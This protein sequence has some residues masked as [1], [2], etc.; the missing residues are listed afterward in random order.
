MHGSGMS[1]D[2]IRH[3]MRGG[4]S[5]Q[6]RQ[7]PVED[8][9]LSP[10]APDEL[11]KFASM[12]ESQSR[13]R[14]NFQFPGNQKILLDVYRDNDE[15]IADFGLECFEFLQKRQAM[16]APGLPE[17]YEHRDGGAF[18]EPVKLPV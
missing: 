12:I 13:E 4:W 1:C 6:I 7:H 18:D 16:T 5:I 3:F 2:V 10:D 8:V 15:S 17:L 11:L 9:I 14:L